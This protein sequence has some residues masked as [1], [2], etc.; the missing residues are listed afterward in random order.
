MNTEFEDLIQELGNCD[1]LKAKH[2]IHSILKDQIQTDNGLIRTLKD[3]VDPKRKKDHKDLLD[4]FCKKNRSDFNEIDEELNEFCDQMWRIND[5]Y[6]GPLHYNY[7][8][9]F[10]NVPDLE[11]SFPECFHAVSTLKDESELDRTIKNR[12]HSII[13]E[14]VYQSLSQGDKSLAGEAGETLVKAILNSVGHKEDETYKAQFKA[15]K[16]SDTDFVLPYADNGDNSKVQICIAAQFS[17]NDRG[18]MAS[19][20]LMPGASRY[21][22]TGNGME[23]STKK[24]KAIGKEI[25]NDF[26][27]DR[28]FIV[29]RSSEKENEINRLKKQLKNDTASKK[30]SVTKKTTPKKQTK[31]LTPT[32]IKTRIKYF[33]EY[34]ITM[35]EFATEMKKRVDEFKREEQND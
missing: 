14:I 20:E 6:Y 24:L 30:K 27:A 31:K 16:G 2:K 32:Q 34:C 35:A 9:L 18:R 25:I 7:L 4:D 23:A 17:S 21:L 28:T 11:H 33:E 12:L 22:V 5:Y 29:C 8:E 3:L 13:G 15:G 10:E 19:S 1:C 26:N